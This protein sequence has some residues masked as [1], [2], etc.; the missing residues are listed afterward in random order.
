VPLQT[1]KEGNGYITLGKSR[2]M[3]AYIRIADCDG[4]PKTS[5][6]IESR[7]SN[8]NALAFVSASSER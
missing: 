1:W 7:E 3:F 4:R 2:S 6:L 5:R 8:T